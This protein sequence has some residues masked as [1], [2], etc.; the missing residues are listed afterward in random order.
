VSDSQVVW[1]VGRG[2]LEGE[3]HDGRWWVRA[4]SVEA[5][6]RRREEEARWVSVVEAARAVGCS[7]NTIVRAA[8]RGEIVQRRAERQRPSLSRASVQEF[9]ETW[10]A[11]VQGRAR[12]AQQQAEHN[13]A[14]LPPDDEHTWLTTREVADLLGV[15][16]SWVNQL[17]RSEQLPVV[18][19]A[20]R[21]WYRADHLRL[22]RNARRAQR[23]LDLSA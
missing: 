17:A 2:H 7:P 1:L 12:A 19:R 11:L 10:A 3:R 9:G 21:H 15:S 5:L 23:Q 13:P 4:G 8:Q 16:R 14:S 20:G 18:S 22:F 6:A